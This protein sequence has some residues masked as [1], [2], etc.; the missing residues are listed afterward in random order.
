MADATL[1]TIPFSHFCEK[2][3]WA[4]DHAGVPYVEEGHMPGFHRLAV[5]RTGSPRTSV[6]VL[7]VGGR[8]LADSTD[9]VAYADAAAA[10]ERKLYPADARTRAEVD[11]LE[12]GFD[13]ILGPNIRR[14]VYFHL[15]P[16]RPVVMELF[17][18]G[19]PSWQRAALR[20]VY[21]L[22]RRG[23]QR[24]MRIDERTAAASL[25]EVLRTFD[26]I[27]KRMSD[28]RPYLAGDRFSAADL[29]FAALAGPAVRP[30]GHPVRFPDPDR[31]PP[32]VVELMRETQERPAGAFVRRLYREHRRAV[33]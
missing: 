15:L 9:I 25:A 5:R 20:V 27:E 23:M 6:P 3:R 2:A 28:G 21:P 14:V 32:A 10:P 7:R 33:A 11:A 29:T 26:A 30:D 31:F 24:F 19:T 12:D 13:E 18:A 16:R 22:L 17:D 8:T 4:L 1:L